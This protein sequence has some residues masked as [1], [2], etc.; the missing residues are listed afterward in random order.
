VERVLLELRL[1]TGLSRDLLHDKGIEAA[2][3]FVD[4][5]LL[6]PYDDRLVLTTKG[7]LLADA[8]VRDLVD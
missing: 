5:G 4:E 6:T 7:R 8:L 2:E 3:R 1:R